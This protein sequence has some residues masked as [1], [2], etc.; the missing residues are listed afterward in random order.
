MTKVIATLILCTAAIVG[1]L[2]FTQQQPRKS[3]LT[4][5]GKTL[6]EHHAA[7]EENNEYV[8]R[9]AV[10]QTAKLGLV[11]YKLDVGSYPS[12]EEGLEALLRAPSG[13]EDKWDGPYMDEVSLASDP[14]GN[15]YNYRFPGSLNGK[16]KDGYDIWS[17]GQDG[18]NSN[19]DIGNW[20]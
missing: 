7:I 20:D 14:W 19:D 10:N 3:E 12:T 5:G 6:A 8:A 15:P 17:L 1:T 16:G 11:A 2:V 18:R 4:I 9:I 13:A